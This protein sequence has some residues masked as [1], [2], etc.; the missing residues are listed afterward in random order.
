[1]KNNLKNETSA[2]KK[3]LKAE[4]EVRMAFV[5]T[6][7]HTKV[8]KFDVFEGKSTF[9]NFYQFTQKNAHPQS[10]L[11]Q[12]ET[13]SYS[14]VPTTKNEEAGFVR[15]SEQHKNDQNDKLESKIEQID[16]RI[17]TPPKKIQ[18]TAN[19]ANAPLIIT[20][21]NSETPHIVVTKSRPNQKM[22]IEE[23]GVQD[24]YE[25]LEND[26]QHHQQSI[27]TTKMTIEPS[28]IKKEGMSHK[29]DLL[30]NTPMNTFNQVFVVDEEND[31]QEVECLD[32][33]TMER[34]NG[35]TATVN[36][37]D[38][39]F[40][41]SD[42]FLNEVIN[43]TANTKTSKTDTEMEQRAM[44]EESMLT[45]PVFRKS[46]KDLKRTTKN[47]ENK[48]KNEDIEISLMEESSI[49]QKKKPSLEISMYNT[50]DE[51]DV[52]NS[53]YL[54]DQ[55]QTNGNTTNTYEKQK[56][57]N[58]EAIMIDDD[59]ISG[60]MDTFDDNEKG[61]GGN[62][63]RGESTTNNPME[64]EDEIQVNECINFDEEGKKMKNTKNMKGQM[65][66][67]AFFHTNR[68]AL[69]YIK[70]YLQVKITN[71][72]A[73]DAELEIKRSLQDDLAKIASLE[74]PSN[75]QQ[76]DFIG[77]DFFDNTKQMGVTNYTLDG[78]QNVQ[79]EGDYVEAVDGMLREESSLINDDSGI[80]RHQPFRETSEGGRFYVWKL[81]E[82]LKTNTGIKRRFPMAVDRRPPNGKGMY[83]IDT[84][85][86]HTSF[87]WDEVALK[88]NHNDFGNDS[89][90]PSQK[91]IINCALSG[92]NTLVLMP[93][94]GGKSLCYQLASALMTGITVVISPLVSLIQDQVANLNSTSLENNVLAYYQGSDFEAGKR[95]FAESKSVCKPK[96]K[97]VFLTPERIQLD[98]FLEALDS[99][100]N[101]RN[102]ALIVVDEA[103][104]VSQW[105]HD[106][107][108]SYQKLSV[109]TQ[110]YPGVPLMML[111][112]TATERV[113]N[114][115]LL[116][117]GVESAVV[118]TQSFNRK[119]L[120]YCV[121]PKTKNVI[122]DIEKLIKTKYRNQSGIV[123]CLSRKN[124]K[125]VCDQLV[126]RGIKACFY[127]AELTPEERQKAQRGWSDGEFD[128]ICATI[129]FGM[130]INKP[131]VR[132]V[133]HHS[134]PKTLE[135]YYQESGRAGRDGEPADCI[136]FYSY[137]DKFVYE[138]FLM[139]DQK[140]NNSDSEHIELSRDNLN[141]VISYC[142]N[143]VD[144]RRT[145]V[146]R[147]FGENFDPK[148]CNK[149]CDNCY[150]PA[151]TEIV[152]LTEIG[153]YV[154]KLVDKHKKITSTMAISILKGAAA[155]AKKYGKDEIGFGSAK[156]R[157]QQ[158]LDQLMKEMCL[159]K[160][161][162]ERIE[163]SVHK[164][165][166]VYL[167]FGANYNKFVSGKMPIN[168]RI[169]KVGHDGVEMESGVRMTTYQSELFETLDNVRQEILEEVQKKTGKGSLLK[170]NLVDTRALNKIVVVMPTT[171][172]EFEEKITMKKNIKSAYG[173]RFV[174]AVNN[175]L[176]EHNRQEVKTTNP[177]INVVRAAPKL[178]RTKVKVREEEEDEEEDDRNDNGNDD[179]I[180]DLINE[181]QDE[182][183]EEEPK[184]KTRKKRTT[185]GEKGEKGEKKMSR[186]TKKTTTN[187]KKKTTKTVK[188]T[189]IK[190]ML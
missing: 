154:V 36:N 160:I 25:A 126:A 41:I 49:V 57:D 184:K 9:E 15:K 121:K 146:L 148:W 52:G 142:E 123:Y 79:M 63:G 128:V 185:A 115:I 153:K 60:L 158:L 144:C 169:K 112:A 48:K 114:D 171:L 65:T 17:T 140:K 73:N 88:Q 136:L 176:R 109:L 86:E 93:T 101:N 77:E 133:I 134:L 78:P 2:I 76:D 20:K 24:I 43:S 165:I 111:T 85:W 131:D 190:P 66:L 96:L 56:G 42:D 6:A 149:T 172:E 70:K 113:Q 94:G 28:I 186:P 21:T 106:F 13:L 55:T 118:F 97:L 12:I 168:V 173:K 99:Y 84:D 129:A 29:N 177:S 117:V 5:D 157:D 187:K 155:A 183:E 51:M 81:N 3:G 87:T 108:E 125:D 22:D 110:R 68:N 156:G 139:E 104:C 100:Y 120:R 143:T 178:S 4:R 18:P 138:R 14:K 182:G 181:M 164:N 152:D 40:D 174:D 135:G 124:T 107:R 175:F 23:D 8:P 19:S 53:V 62:V 105:G 39:P 7:L 30:I 103:H 83:P 16:D 132:F 147:Y 163:E 150:N 151:Q 170:H 82:F 59:D 130:G 92:H 89:F 159:S 166:V 119:N 162:S 47:K 31:V 27:T 72:E 137:R 45:E 58:H 80:V 167:R 102:F 46:E 188:S 141:Q 189:F 98:S 1:M 74:Q 35:T 44:E 38:D 37:K 61:K 54:G 127:H 116:S 50:E 145:M 32:V 95:F 90:R 69:G 75:P 11:N 33:S 26:Q 71:L 67:E 64:M 34:T 10:V 122:D 179:D 91:A 180:L 161:L